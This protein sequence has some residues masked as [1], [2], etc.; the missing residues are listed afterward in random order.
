MLRILSSKWSSFS[1]R[2]SPLTS[3]TDSEGAAADGMVNED[4]KERQDVEEK[5]DEE[6]E[7]EFHDT[8]TELIK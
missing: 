5:K 4:G 3:S 1:S 6:E 2:G 8:V 7:E